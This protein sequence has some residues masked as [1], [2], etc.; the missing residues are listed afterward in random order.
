MTMQPTDKITVRADLI[1]LLITL[2]WG[3]TFV[4]VK[5]VLSSISPMFFQGYRF[6][7]ASL[8]LVPFLWKNIRSFDKTTIKHGI[9]LGIYL[10]VG[11]GL[12]TVGLQ[13]TS[14]SKSAFLTGMMVVLTPIFQLLLERRRPTRGNVIGIVL[15]TIGLFLLTAPTGS[16]FNIGDLMTIGCAIIFA[17][18]IVYLDIYTKDAFRPENVFYQ[19]LTT[20]AL[21]F[22]GALIIEEPIFT[23]ES[24][25]LI[26]IVYLGLFASAIATFLQSK[27]Q[28]DTTPTRAAIIFAMEPV[29]ASIFAYFIL[30][31]VFTLPSL[32]G[33]AS[34]LSGLLV[35]ELT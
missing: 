32:I 16:A 7:F 20:S 27:F 26:A 3:S 12:Q 14:A 33:A 11:F 22:I 4:I 25:V 29:V 23:A 19:L 1:L 30:Q 34:I 13:Y 2:I 24:S 28:R 5:N 15:V 35:S 18:Y 17:V 21:G 6:A 31:E 8:V 10:G 9:I